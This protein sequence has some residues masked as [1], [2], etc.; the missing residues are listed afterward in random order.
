[1]GIGGEGL[2]AQHVCF[3]CQKPVGDNE[4]HIHVPMDDWAGSMGLP[5]V[6][7]DDLLTMV[8]CEPCTVTSDRRGWQLESHEVAR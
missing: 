2:D 7:L 3:G 1:M 5:P 4:P 6:G 8:F